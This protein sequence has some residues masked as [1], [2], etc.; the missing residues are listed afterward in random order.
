MEWE[1]AAVEKKHAKRMK[2]WK[3]EWEIKKKNRKEQWK[4][5]RAIKEGIDRTFATIRSVLERQSEMDKVETDNG[6]HKK[7]RVA[8]VINGKEDEAGKRDGNET[9]N[10]KQQDAKDGCREWEKKEGCDCGGER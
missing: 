9:M 4:Q 6:E 7:V 3:E 10:E 2:K 8:Q 1:L 5:Y